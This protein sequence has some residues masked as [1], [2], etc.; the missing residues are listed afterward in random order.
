MDGWNLEFGR[1]KW[2]VFFW[3]ENNSELQGCS[4]RAIFSGGL[5]EAKTFF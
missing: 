3:G 4:K 2:G 5:A 1:K